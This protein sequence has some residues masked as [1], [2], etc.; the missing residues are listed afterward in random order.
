MIRR[1]P[2]KRST[3]PIARRTRV[4]PKRD[5]PRRGPFRDRAYLDFLASECKCVAC[6]IHC[7][8]HGYKPGCAL[9]VEYS[10]GRCDPAHYKPNGRGSKGPD[11]EAG[12]LCRGHHDYQTEIGW[13]RFE[14]LYKLDWKAEAATHYAAYLIWKEATGV[15]EE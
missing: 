15:I 5:T 3:K 12:P 9:C 11:N 8:R 4:K 13:D 14:E 7:I 1:T 6:K 10:L 2:L